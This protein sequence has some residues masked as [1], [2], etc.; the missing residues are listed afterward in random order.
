MKRAKTKTI[1]KALCRKLFDYDTATGNLIWRKRKYTGPAKGVDPMADSHRKGVNIFNAKFAGK[2]AGC[3]KTTNG[4]RCIG[5]SNH[6]GIHLQHRLV[7]T[8]HYGPPKNNVDHR[9]NDPMNN[10]IENLREATHAQNMW[11]ARVSRNSSTG[12]KGVTPRGKKFIATINV[13]GLAKYIGMYGDAA[14]AKAARDAVAKF[15]HG[16]FART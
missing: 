8:W 1:S 16:S 9:D 5:I 4:Y 3:E 11:N 2:I 7:W 15:L 12:L 10:R 13:N 6:G 14:T